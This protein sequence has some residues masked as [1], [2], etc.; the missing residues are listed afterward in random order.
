MIAFLGDMGFQ[1][2][3]SLLTKE[4]ALTYGLIKLPE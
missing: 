1:S 4:L 3:G 2:N